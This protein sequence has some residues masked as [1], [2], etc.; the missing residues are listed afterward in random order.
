MLRSKLRDVA[1]VP[2]DNF[3]MLVNDNC[4]LADL[5]LVLVA[6]M[7]QVMDAFVYLGEMVLYFVLESV[8]IFICYFPYLPFTARRSPQ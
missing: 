8:M 4:M 5:L 6:L 2:V 1:F 3:L 7:L